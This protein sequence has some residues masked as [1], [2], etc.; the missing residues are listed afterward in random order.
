MN[1]SNMTTTEKKKVCVLH[2]HNTECCNVKSKNIIHEGKTVAAITIIL[3]K[4]FVCK[5]AS[6]PVF[7][8][9]LSLHSHNPHPDVRKQD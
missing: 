2:Q 4:Q 6:I 3:L 7:C 9:N 5:V 8:Y 1:K